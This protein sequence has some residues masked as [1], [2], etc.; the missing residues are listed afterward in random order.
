MTLQDRSWDDPPSRG[1]SIENRQASSIF[2][3]LPPG[4]WSDHQAPAVE[5][6]SPGVSKKKPESGKMETCVTSGFSWTAKDSFNSEPTFE[7]FVRKKMFVS[8]KCGSDRSHASLTK[9]TWSHDGTRGSCLQVEPSFNF[10]AKR[11][12]PKNHHAV[13]EINHPGEGRI[14]NWSILYLGKLNPILLKQIILLK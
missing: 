6:W 5:V 2:L 10:R 3:P 9:T 7:S 14:W 4:S 11:V 8:C 1:Q 12:H 13:V